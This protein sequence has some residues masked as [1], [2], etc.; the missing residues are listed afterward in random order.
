MNELMSKFPHV[1]HLHW[2]LLP[3]KTRWAFFFF[4]HLRLQLDFKKD[5]RS[6]LLLLPHRLF[7]LRGEAGIP[8][9]REEAMDQTVDSFDAQIFVQPEEILSFS[10]E[11]IHLAPDF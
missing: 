8:R 5:T 7:F 11:Q 1:E 4:L 3:L 2:A 10:W 6:L 9:F